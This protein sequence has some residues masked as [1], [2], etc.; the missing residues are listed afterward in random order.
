MQYLVGIFMCVFKWFVDAGSNNE[1]GITASKILLAGASIE[2]LMQRQHLT[3]PE[4]HTIELVAAG[5]ALHRIIP[6]RGILQELYIIQE[7]PTP[8]Y[9]DSMST[10]YVAL[11]RAAVKKSDP[12]TYAE[13]MS[14]I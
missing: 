4:S 14:R 8:L 6:I 1:V 13:R 2:T 11:D 7:R 10:L 9:M 12:G 3:A 5:T